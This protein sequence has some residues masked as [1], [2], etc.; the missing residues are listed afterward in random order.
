MRELNEESKLFL[1][2]LLSFVS[3]LNTIYHVKENFPFKD[4]YSYPESR[5]D[6]Y[7]G[8]ILKSCMIVGRKHSVV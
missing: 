6:C 1:S 4:V 5:H 7:T 3:V 2:L 8:V